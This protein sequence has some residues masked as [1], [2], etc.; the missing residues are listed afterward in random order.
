MQSVK[1]LEFHPG[2]RAPEFLFALLDACLVLAGAEIAYVFRFEDFTAWSNS[3]LLLVAFN[4]AMTALLFPT[5]G[6]Y[7]SWRG[8]NPL[9]MVTL[10]TI[11][12]VAVFVLGLV[13]VFTTHQA[14]TLSRLWCGTWLITSLALLVALR[15]AQYQLSKQLW[16][17][18]INVQPVA[19]VGANPLSLM[20][21][22]RLRKN[23]QSGFSPECVFDE[24]PQASTYAGGLPV[25]ASLDGLADAVRTRSIKEIWLVLPL[26]EEARVHAVLNAFRHDF[27]NVRFIPNV[28]DISLFNHSVSEVVGLSAIN[29]L[30]SPSAD[31][32][33]V[34]KQIF[35]R[36]FAALALLCLLPL[37]LVIGILVK[38]S[39][40]GP[41]FFRQWRKG[42]NGNEFQI[43][44]FRT[45]VVHSEDAGQ[46]TQAKRR[47]PRVTPIGALLRKTSLDELPQFIN[48]LKGDMSVVGPR[49]HALQHDELYKDLV[50][51]YMFRYR[52]K[53]G[54]TGWAQING[55]RGETDKI[56]KMQGRIA[57]DLYYIE[58]WTF[59]LDLK[60]VLKTF[61]HGFSGAQAY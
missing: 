3:T 45:M 38:L 37:M 8:R 14:H 21:I 36:T 34:P 11:G 18:G 56:E 57:F 39:S 55:Y 35:D 5:L 16:R 58:N 40:P 52:I 59:G 53:P 50:N 30:A 24:D 44:K 9:E 17:R 27:V 6:I 22:D 29:L 4:T 26:R 46:L 12:W 28:R 25:I 54:I 2:T 51:G 7:Q 32:R 60:I 19:I 20:L 41:V 15:I 1:P 61:I 13:L 33:F 48:V 42:A 23:A 10:V 43:Y 47:D 49:P 31:P